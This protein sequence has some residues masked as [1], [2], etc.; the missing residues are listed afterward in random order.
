MPPRLF[1]R[2][3]LISGKTRRRMYEATREQWRDFD[4][5]AM[6]QHALPH[7]SDAD[8][9]FIITGITEE[10]WNDSVKEEPEN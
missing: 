5:G 4:E 7:L 9:E 10:E 3:S 1:T 8:R 6:I 2:T